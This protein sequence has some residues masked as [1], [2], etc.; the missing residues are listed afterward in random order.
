MYS[1]GHVTELNTI[2]NNI[3]QFEI[4]GLESSAVMVYRRKHLKN[5]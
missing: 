3:H 1:D 5:K 2:I 4:F